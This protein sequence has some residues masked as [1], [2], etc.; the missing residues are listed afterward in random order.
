MRPRLAL[1]IALALA[2]AVPGGAAAQ[3]ASRHVGANSTAQ[4][5]A[6]GIVAVVSLSA[7]P[8]STADALSVA[9]AS[10]SEPTLN[11][12]QVGGGFTTPVYGV[13][14][15]LE[16]YFGAATYDPTFVVA[17]STASAQVAADW[18]SYA[19]TGGI[20]VDF[21][22]AERVIFR[23]IFNFSIGRVISE[24]TVLTQ[25]RS[26][27]AGVASEFLEDGHLNAIGLGG[28]AMLAYQ[29]RSP[30][31]E[32][33]AEIR[34]TLMWLNSIGGTSA[35]VDGTADASALGFWGR[36]R[37][38]TGLMVFDRPLR[39]VF[40]LAH[41]QFLG[42][43]ADVLGFDYLT[44]VGAGLELDVG[45]LDLPLERARLVVSYVFGEKISGVS[46]GIGFSF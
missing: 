46:F 24:A 14:L 12:F 29:M 19:A 1:L 34:Y 15:Y 30:E 9:S 22:V 26:A 23:P 42:D 33:D 11:L 36:V 25:F 35:G 39:G 21:P 18:T 13:P 4:E 40:Q 2:P 41:S 44:K 45:A 8:D 6:N 28:A 37:V 43:Q 5:A 16:G 38:P 20:G 3:Q 27:D 10:G 32:V 31:V 17:D 7:V